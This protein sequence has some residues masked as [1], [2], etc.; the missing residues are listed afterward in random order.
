MSSLVANFSPFTYL[1]NL[2]NLGAAL[3]NER[4]TLTGGDNQLERDGRLTGHHRVD[5]R[6]VATRVLSI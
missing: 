4:A 3:A 5:G 1:S 2:L 6:R